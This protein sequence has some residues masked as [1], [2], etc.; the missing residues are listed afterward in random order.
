MLLAAPY[1]N[2]GS[3]YDSQGQYE[4]ALEYY[5]KSLDIKI[6]VVGHEH[7]DVAA[8]YNNMG[9]VYDS[10]G[11]YE[12]ALEHHQKAL[13]IRTR[14]VGY[15]HPLVADSKYNLALLHKKRSRKTSWADALFL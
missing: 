11:H 13:D 3:V 2:M 6:R 1:L 9:R 15:K 10:Q 5:Q 7:L 8:S 4:R 12:R 14:V